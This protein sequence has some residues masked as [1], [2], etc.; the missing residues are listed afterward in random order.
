MEFLIEQFFLRYF[1]S[2]QS[3]DLPQLTGNETLN[4]KAYTRQFC[5]DVSITAYIADSWDLNL[6][7]S[8]ISIQRQSM[9]S[10]LYIIFECATCVMQNAL[11][12]VKWVVNPWILWAK[13]QVMNNVTYVY[14]FRSF[15]NL[16]RNNKIGAVDISFTRKLS[17]K[18]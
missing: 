10:N 6:P 1:S 3:L 12:F 15:K 16:H 11:C 8:I 18:Y 5:R 17:K 14:I 7:Q 2:I 4:L 9:F 13:W